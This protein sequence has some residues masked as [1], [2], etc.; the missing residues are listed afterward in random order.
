MAKYKQKAIRR[1]KHQTNDGKPSFNHGKPPHKGG[2]HSGGRR[3]AFFTIGGDKDG[4]PKIAEIK[5]ASPWRA[6][7][8]RNKFKSLKVS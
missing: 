8:R 2:V 3:K 1:S 6:N 7:V 4:S 5:V